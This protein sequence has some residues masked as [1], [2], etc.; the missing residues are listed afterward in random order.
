MYSRSF[1]NHLTRGEVGQFSNPR[2]FH[3]GLPM[4]ELLLLAAVAFAAGFCT[5]WSLRAALARAVLRDMEMVYE[6]AEQIEN[7]EIVPLV[8]AHHPWTYHE[9]LWLGTDRLEELYKDRGNRS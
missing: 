1:I 6:K 2:S 9:L 3:R 8:N 4:T 7:G 5:G